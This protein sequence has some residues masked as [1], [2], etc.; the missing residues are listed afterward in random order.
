[1]SAKTSMS[2]FAMFE[3][4]VAVFLLAIGVLGLAAVQMKTYAVTRDADYRTSAAMHAEGL[5]E[6][7]RANPVR[8][9]DASS[10]MSWSFHHYDSNGT[11]TT[12]STLTSTDCASTNCNQEALA[13]YDLA[14]FLKN[15]KASFPAGDVYARVCPE[16]D[17]GQLPTPDDMGCTTSGAMTIK[18]AWRSRATQ[19][20][21]KA[22]SGTAASGTIVSGYQLKV[23][24]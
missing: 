1:M 14:E 20:E 19:A 17:F 3:V 13:D 11:L 21:I 9:L 2:G 5:A 7:M 24:P 16:S 22:V 8:S 6:A 4:L 10:V 18:V 23:E 15:L 12:S